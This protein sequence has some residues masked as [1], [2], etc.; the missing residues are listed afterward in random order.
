MKKG[1]DSINKGNRRYH[2]CCI[3]VM[4]NIIISVVVLCVLSG[5]C[6][7]FYSGKQKERPVLPDGQ[8]HRTAQPADKA[9]V[10]SAAQNVQ[11]AVV[12][13]QNVSQEA[14]QNSASPQGVI[15]EN[16]RAA[17]EQDELPA[18]N[19]NAGESQPMQ[20]AELADIQQPEQE[21]EMA[22]T[23]EHAET[24][25]NVEYFYPCFVS[26]DIFA[27]IQGHSYKDNCTIPLEELRYIR[28]L[29]VGF[30]GQDHEGELIVNRLIAE[31]VCAVFRELYEVRYPIEKIRLVDE[32]GADDNRSMAD[33]NSSAFNYRVIDGTERLSNHAKGF[34]ID[35]NP[36]YN[37]YIR[38]RNGVQQVLPDHAYEY[39]DRT[40]DHPYYIKKGDTCYQ[41]FKSHGFT[42][43]GEWKNSKDY[44]HFEK[45]PQ[46]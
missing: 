3:R 43:G 17:S 36:L 10:R 35:V 28:V 2:A 13:L 23:E 20:E 22:M 4:R 25:T 9:A 27:R 26:A 37:P 41:I 42:W 5:I 46:E 8:K 12:H 31:E 33:N 21:Q 24:T 15:S 18:G 38:T 34:A 30:D 29:H 39:A 6:Y 40:K 19:Q 32:Y 1:F 44:Q 16:Q 7:L 14:C 11:N 45:V